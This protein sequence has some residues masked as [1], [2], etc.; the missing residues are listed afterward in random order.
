MC[1]REAREALCRRRPK[2]AMPLVG[3]AGQKTSCPWHARVQTGIWQRHRALPALPSRRLVWPEH[4]GWR[5]GPTWDRQQAAQAAASGG[6]A[7]LAAEQQRRRQL[8]P[9][10][11]VLVV[12]VVGAEL[13]PR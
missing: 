7:L 6:R 13:E 4:L 9:P 2:E 11:G 5:W 8:P 3:T 10:L 1:N 12:E